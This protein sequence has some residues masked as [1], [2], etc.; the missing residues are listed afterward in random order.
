MKNKFGIKIMPREVILD[1]QG[2]AVQQSLK[3]NHL[4]AES[5][6]VGKYIEIEIEGSIEFARKQA[7]KMTQ[8]L[9]CNSLIENY[10]II[11]IK[12]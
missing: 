1:T 6:R 12:S 2:R 11:E 3:L 10:E 9:L 7:E 5:V 8:S 4:D